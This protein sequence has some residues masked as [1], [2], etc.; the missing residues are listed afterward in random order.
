MRTEQLARMFDRSRRE[1]K[2]WRARCPCHGGKSLTLAIYAYEDRSRVH[3]YAGCEAD[4]VLA[5]VG[6]TRKQLFY[7]DKRLERKE[8]LEQKRK[9]DAEESR[10]SQLRIGTWIIR[11]A[12]RGYTAEEH[13][14]DVAVVTACK[15]VL[16][17]NDNRPWKH[18]YRVHT[19]KIAA[20]D[21]CRKRSMLPEVAQPEWE[22]GGK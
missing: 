16:A 21:H 19:E 7:E 22:L 18:I 10:A 14:Q 20:G 3:C 11:F 4:D 12:E 9:R 2:A 6:L 1:G 17:H 15:A 8:W 5:A 13:E